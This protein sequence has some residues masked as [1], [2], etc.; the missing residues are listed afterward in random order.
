[1]NRR[2]PAV[3]VVEI[4]GGNSIS[5]H[6]RGMLGRPVVDART[7]MGRASPRR[8]CLLRDPR[9]ADCTPLTLAERA[10]P[11]P[12]SRARAVVDVEIG[13]AVPHGCAW[14]SRPSPARAKAPRTGKEVKE[15]GNPL[16][17]PASHALGQ[18]EARAPEHR[19]P[20]R[21]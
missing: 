17:G 18:A 4:G 2:S 9:H 20:C 21:R 8:S 15:C 12:S 3:I 11:T 13:A 5:V 6:G 7:C 14:P 1:M 19:D 16:Y 10:R